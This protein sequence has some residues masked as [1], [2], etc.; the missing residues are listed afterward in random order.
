MG[1]CN[2]Q[3]C[4]NPWLIHIA[5]WLSCV[6]SF[7]VLPVESALAQKPGP[8][9][10]NQQWT[11]AG[12]EFDRGWKP[13]TDLEQARQW[14][15]A[16]EKA[17]KGRDMKTI[18]SLLDFEPVLKRCAAGITN[19]A[20]RKGFIRG[21]RTGTDQLLAQLSSEK[22]S[23]IFRGVR[24]SEYGAGAIMRMLDGNG[25][26]NYHLWRLQENDQGQVVGVDMYVYLSGESFGDTIRRLTL[27]SVPKDDR[28]FFQRLSGTE[29]EI[30]KNQA[31]MLKIVQGM[32]QQNFK[33]TLDGYNQLPPKLKKEKAFMVMRIM[34]ALQ[35]DE[36]LY[37]EALDDFQKVFPGD[38][39]ADLAGIDLF[40]LKKEFDKMHEAIDRLE[41]AVGRDGHLTMLRGLGYSQEGKMEAAEK[42]L[43]EA[44]AIEPGLEGPYWSLVEFGLTNKKFAKVTGTL[45]KLSQQF[46][47]NQFD[48]A[49]NQVYA[50]YLKSAEYQQ[51]KEY[52]KNR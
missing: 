6:L 26:C 45:K 24:N 10:V 18:R 30:T 37:V 12:W 36:D 43:T 35:V 8:D 4:V 17:M 13:V 38:A 46:G 40:F 27:L 44:I 20:F 29:S 47:Y 41:N 2:A 22:G 28:T 15:K 7:L 32:Q 51:F 16:V 9:Q 19:D 3:I 39:S 50:E 52:L 1:S 42:A 23:Y 11:K 48:L 21:V 25:G 5:I 14:A 49:S 33:M 34:A 31:Q